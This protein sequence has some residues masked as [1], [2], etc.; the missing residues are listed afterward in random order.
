[1]GASRDFDFFPAHPWRLDHPTNLHAQNGSDDVDSRKDVPFAVKIATFHT[2]PRSPGPLKGQNVANF[3]LINFCVPIISKMAGDSDLA[4][5]GAP[6]GNGHLGI[7]WS[8][9]R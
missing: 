7:E 5:N 1:M 4:D 8:R 3:G 6:V 9:D 2:R